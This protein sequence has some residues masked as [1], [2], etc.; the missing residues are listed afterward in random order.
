[1]IDDQS[2]L[3]RAVEASGIGTVHVVAW[4]DFDDP[5]A[6]GSELHA[7]EILKRWA[8]AGVVV[9]ARTSMVPGRAGR[10][11]RHGY[12]VIRRSGRYQIFPSVVMKGLIGRR[13][14]R[15]DA[16]VEIWNGMPFLS[17][18]WFRG[19]RLVLLHHVHGEMWQMTLPGILGRLGWLVEHRLAPPFYHH[20]PIATLSNSS[21]EEIEERMHL[22]HVAVV[23][24]GISPRF[25]PGRERSP[26][27]L[28]VAVGR[29]VPVKRFNLLIESFVEVRKAV[30]TAQFVIVGEGYLRTELEELVAS[31]G[32]Q[33]WISLP[34]RISDDA[35]VKLY[36]SAW[37]IGSTSLREGWGMS[38]TEAAACGTPSVAVDIAGHRDAVMHG[39]SGLLVTEAMMAETIATVLCDEQQLNQLRSGA[40]EYARTLTWDSAAL[41]LFK[42]FGERP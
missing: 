36:Q 32:A 35:L 20:T 30:P 22:R 19:R 9:E 27:P 6:G 37:L 2:E 7:D 21:Q 8:A 5:E 39:L 31:H 13:S 24:P 40:L 28:V 12:S 34:G 38:L 1:M 4:R 33:S 10:V 29:L 14:Q 25:T 16:V 11:E 15:P 3:R 17:P 42:L 23:P 26:V 18:I 41:R